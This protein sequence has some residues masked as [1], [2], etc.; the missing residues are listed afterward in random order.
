MTSKR[1][2]KSKSKKAAVR[3]RAVTP[4]DNGAVPA[5]MQAGGAAPSAALGP[6]EFAV[7]RSDWRASLKYRDHVAVKIVRR[8]P[9]VCPMGDETANDDAAATPAAPTMS[10][11]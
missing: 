8:A 2:T 11:G 3:S 6:L 5:G 10:N 7:Y 9:I 1:D 4:E